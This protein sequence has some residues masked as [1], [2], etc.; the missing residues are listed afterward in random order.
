MVVPPDAVRALADALLEHPE[1]ALTVLSA[2]RDGSGRVVDFHYELANG[3]A[4]RNAGKALQGRRMLEVWAGQDTSLF[5]PMVELLRDGGEMRFEY[6]ASYPGADPAIAGRAYS[7]YVRAAG[8]EHVV[9]QFRDITEL[10]RAQ[11]LLHTQALHDPLTGLANRRLLLDHLEQAL[12]RL[13]RRSSTLAVLYCDVDRFKQINDTFGHGVGDRL[14]QLVGSSLHAALRP[15]DTI[16]RIGGDEFVVLCED[17]EPGATGLDLAERLRSAVPAICRIAGTDV[18]VGVSVGVTTLTEPV[19]ADRALSE[20]DTALYAAKQDGRRQSRLFSDTMREQSLH[21]YR[22]E[23]GLA[24]ALERGEFELHHQP[25]VD[26]ASGVVTGAEA[27][28]RW[29][30]PTDGLLLPGAF[31]DVLEDSAGILDVGDWVLREACAEAAGWPRLGSTAVVQVNLAARQIASPHLVGQVRAALA[32]SGLAAERLELEITEGQV[33]TDLPGAVWTLEEVRALGVRV[34][35]DDFGSGYSS[36]AWL[37]RLPVTSLKLDRTFLADLNGSRSNSAIVRAVVDLGHA[38][39]LQV[40][41]EGV[42]DEAQL[43]ALRALGVDEVQGFHLGRPVP[44]A[45]FRERL[46]RAAP[47]ARGDGRGPAA[48][49]TGG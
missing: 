20:A 15:A 22:T 47:G 2:V 12:A 4:E 38:L 10:R 34:A 45:E 14:L 37:Q 23:A 39:G 30:H 42:E 6:E 29:R 7:S 48:P 8:T 31:L 49:V 44:A 3:A 11:G 43:R 27:L 25:K 19:P 18:H 24:V 13:E 41:G 1:D 40:V 35:L 9:Q 28:L 17:L 5:V 46:R 36:L 16:A 26:L 32:R 33:L 21:R